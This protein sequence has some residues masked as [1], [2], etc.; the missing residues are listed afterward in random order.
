[1]SGQVVHCWEKAGSYSGGGVQPEER[2]EIERPKG[3]KPHSLSNKALNYTHITG[4]P[5]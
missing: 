2:G 1:M 5:F 3:P 4:N